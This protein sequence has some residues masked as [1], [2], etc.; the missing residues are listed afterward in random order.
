MSE[1][2]QP[3]VW[4]GDALLLLDQTRLP[5]EERWQRCTTVDEVA[6]AIR[7]MRVR[8]APA[9]GLAAAAGMALAAIAAEREGKQIAEALADAAAT[10]RATRP[11]A[12]NLTWALHRAQKV[13]GEVSDPRD[14]TRR[15][16][17][18]VHALIADQ[19]VSDLAI[20]ERGASLL[21]ARARVLTHCNTGSLATGAVGTA[22]GIVKRAHELGKLEMVYVGE[23]R[24]RLQ[25]AR[26]TSWELRE[27]GIPF[28][29]IVDAAAA[30]LMARG[31]VDAVVVGADRIA[32]NGDVANKIGTLALAIAAQRFGVPFY[33]AAPLSTLDVQTSAG[34]LIEIEERDPEEV[35]SLGVER[36]APQGTLVLNPAF[37][38]TPAELVT[39]LVT[40]IGTVTA[41]IGDNLPALAAELMS[42]NDRS[43]P[44]EPL[45]ETSPGG[46]EHARVAVRLE[47]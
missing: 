13:V 32:A 20:A 19:M 10:L 26:L 44:A 31:M 38:V 30:S 22:L 3:I 40:E 36:I 17:A 46:R 28:R 29:L 1:R 33:V 27:A 21:P 42:R 24:P 14:V 8:G 4:E 23:S 37:D 15:L 9:I 5:R 7:D 2:L 12:V 25:G 11:T 39:A 43:G 6:A 47:G 41:P 34:E 16:S 18:L 35:L 45:G